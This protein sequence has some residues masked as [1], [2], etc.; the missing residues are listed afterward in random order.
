MRRRCLVFEMVGSRR[1]QF[2]DGSSCGPSMLSQSHDNIASNDKRL[3]PFKPGND[4]PRRVLPGIGL[5]L[6]AL[7]ATSADNKVVKHE[8]LVT[9]GQPISVSRSAAYFNSSNSQDISN[10]S[11]VVSSS[12]RET[13]PAEGGAPIVEDAAQTSGYAINEVFNHSSPKKKRHV[14]FN[15]R[16]NIA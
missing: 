11:L 6:N 5:H 9:G 10:N 7:A 2:D 16:D 1:K 13:V 8:A 4:T 14:W 12:E 3:I 15:Y